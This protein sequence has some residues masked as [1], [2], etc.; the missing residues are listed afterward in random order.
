M[1]LNSSNIIDPDV[2][3]NKIY[4][5]L[6]YLW[7]LCLIPLL[8]R[9]GSSFAQ[10]HAKQGFVLFVVQV[11]VSLLQF[12][13]IFGQ[14]LLVLVIILSVVGIIKAYNGERWEMPFIYQW[15]KKISL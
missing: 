7:I 5:V 12:I 2:E 14:I 15:S 6:S 9:R 3:A 11:I 4:A 8:F 13:P 1:T 10:F